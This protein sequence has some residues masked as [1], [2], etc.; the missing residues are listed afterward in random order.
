MPGSL[1][2]HRGQIVHC[3]DNTEAGLEFFTDGLLLVENGK[4][5]DLGPAEHLL[6]QLSADTP[7]T[8]HGEHLICP[9]L[10]DCHVHFPQLDV[11]A[12]YG[13][14]LLDW[15]ETY[16]FPSEARYG[17]PE[18]AQADASFF[19]DE[20][21]RNGTTSA[22]VFA[23]V[24]Q[25]SVDAIFSAAKQ[26]HMRLAAGK[27]LMDRNCPANLQDTPASAYHESRALIEKWHHQERLLYAIT[28]RFAATS[29]NAQ[30]AAAGQLAEEFPDT[31][32]H[33]H[34]SENLDEVAWIAELFPQA[35]SYLDVYAGHGLLRERSVFAHCIHL[36]DEDYR[37]FARHG[38][39]MAFC[40][41]SNLFLGSGLFDLKKANMY[42]IN[43]GLGTD[44]GGG[45]SFS[46]L[47]TINAAYKVLQMQKQSLHSADAL[48]LATLGGARTLGIDDKV[49][50]FLPGK[51]ADFIILDNA[52]TPLLARRLSQAHTHNDALFMHM[53]LGDD[54]SI[55]ETYILGELAYQKAAAGA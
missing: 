28:P 36:D 3:L 17:D 10:I 55:S 24:H 43:V 29:S 41:S 12:S 32:I 8:D 11:I 25:T 44:V 37:E 30:L 22:L 13:A 19:I 47:Q 31:L 15:L 14:Q 5:L 16:T 27:V 46:L 33:T 7:V 2:A 21:L 51:E 49:G 18:I 20:L 52:P 4:V 45:T 48:Y 50:N 39:G 9:G 38:G 6:A 54:R 40:P 42:N 35:R 26:R 53:I 1:T 34:L 23:S